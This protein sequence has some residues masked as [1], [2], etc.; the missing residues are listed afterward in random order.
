MVSALLLVIP[1]GLGW[2][3]DK[4]MHSLP[5]FTLVGLVLGIVW[6]GRYTY[7]EIRKIF[8]D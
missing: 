6:A 3:A 5:I 7:L 8:R 4:A 1:F 2:F